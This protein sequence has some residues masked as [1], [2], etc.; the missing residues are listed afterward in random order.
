MNLAVS[1]ANRNFGGFCLLYM[2]CDH[3]GQEHDR[4]VPL[5][6][7]GSPCCWAN[8]GSL[9]GSRRRLEVEQFPALCFPGGRS[10]G[11]RIG[12]DGP[13]SWV[14]N[15]RWAGPNPPLP[16]LASKRRTRTWGTRL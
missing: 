5:G 9:L 15:V 2:G 8:L 4:L 16:R 14:E 13:R 6:A 10:G 7:P 11:N 12:M 1:T 3:N